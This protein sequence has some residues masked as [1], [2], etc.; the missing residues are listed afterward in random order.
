MLNGFFFEAQKFTKMHRKHGKGLAGSSMEIK[1]FMDDFLT[2]EKNDLRR[3]A[4][5]IAESASQAYR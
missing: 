3:L 2:K 5:V 4:E 1:E